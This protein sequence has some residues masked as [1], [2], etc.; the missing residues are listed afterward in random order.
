MV[1]GDVAARDPLGEIVVKLDAH[2]YGLN[3]VSLCGVKQGI[4]RC[5]GFTLFDFH[6]L[7]CS[8]TGH[9]AMVTSHI[10]FCSN[11]DIHLTPPIIRKPSSL[12][13]D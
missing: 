8:S 2:S 10:T 1:G 6:V 11:L 4:T 12:F 3:E 5:W 9:T 13:K 7:S